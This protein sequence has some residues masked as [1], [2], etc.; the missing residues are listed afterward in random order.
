MGHMNDKDIQPKPESKLS[1]AGIGAIFVVVFLLLM[2]IANTKRTEVN[3]IVYKA[4]D[5]PVWWLMVVVMAL[6]LIIERLVGIAWRRSKRK[7]DD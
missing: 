1:P 6:T 2:I 3:F 7:K 4:T 5:I